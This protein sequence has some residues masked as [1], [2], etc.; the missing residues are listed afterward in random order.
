MICLTEAHKNLFLDSMA[1]AIITLKVELD[2]IHKPAKFIVS[3]VCAGRAVTSFQFGDKMGYLQKWQRINCL[4]CVIII[5]RL[6]LK[7]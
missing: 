7:F 1:V 2:R 3:H 4:G 5:I 6:F